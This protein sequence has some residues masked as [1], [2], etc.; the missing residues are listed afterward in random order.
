MS[1]EDGKKD[2]KKD[3]EKIFYYFLK[4]DLIFIKCCGIISKSHGEMA[5][6]V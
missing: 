5:E 2:D 3:K 6:L 4:K 1:I